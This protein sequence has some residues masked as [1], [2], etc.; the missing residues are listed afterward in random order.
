MDFYQHLFDY[1][2]KLQFEGF[3]CTLE[4]RD[5]SLTP[6]CIPSKGTIFFSNT[7]V[8]YFLLYNFASLTLVERYVISHLAFTLGKYDIATIFLN[9]CSRM[10]IK[11]NKKIVKR[12]CKD[13]HLLADQMLFLLF[14]EIGHCHFNKDKEYKQK[15]IDLLPVNDLKENYGEN[16]EKGLP[17]IENKAPFWYRLIMPKGSTERSMS[18]SQK[19]VDFKTAKNRYLEELACDRYALEQIALNSQHLEEQGLFLMNLYA[20]SIKALYGIGHDVE[21]ESVFIPNEDPTKSEEELSILHANKLQEYAFRIGILQLSAWDILS[22]FENEGLLKQFSKL[23]KNRPH[24]KS[25]K[26][27]FY[28]NIDYSLFNSF[29]DKGEITKEEYTMNRNKFNNLVLSIFDE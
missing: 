1:V 16:I 28:H 12:I 29:E 18:E 20:Y 21:T 25:I 8:V 15:I 26:E 7:Q 17:E 14:H 10:F 22:T 27:H 4:N 5:K 13:P 9:L 19:L 2:S 23:S 3:N 24:F 6:S 11:E